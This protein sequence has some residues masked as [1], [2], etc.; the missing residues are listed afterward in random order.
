MAFQDEM[1]PLEIVHADK[2]YWE[3]SK[4]SHQGAV[5]WIKTVLSWCEIYMKVLRSICLTPFKI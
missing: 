4:E 2:H 1:N 5:I 3:I